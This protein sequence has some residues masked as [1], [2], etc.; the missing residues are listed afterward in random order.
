[1]SLD[2]PAN[3]VSVSGHYGPHSELYHQQVLQRL[4]TAVGDSEGDDAATALRAELGNIAN[5]L[6]TPGDDLRNLI[7]KPGC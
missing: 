6:S 3:I 7:V 2:D 1:M 4:R 5:D